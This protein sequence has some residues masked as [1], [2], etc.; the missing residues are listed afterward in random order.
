MKT[1]ATVIMNNSATSTKCSLDQSM[2]TI[3]LIPWGDTWEDWFDSVGVSFDDFCNELTGGW[4]NNY[5]DALRLAG[6]Q[7]I[8]IYA[9]AR[10]TEPS[11]FIH[12]P[13][14]ATICLLPTSKTYAAIRRQMIHPYPSL[15]YSESFEEMFGE[16]KGAKRLLLWVLKYLAPYLAMPL[17]LLI[18]EL[19]QYD[20]KA[21]LC[22]DYEQ[23]RFDVCVVLG[24]LLGLPVYSTFQGGTGDWNRIGRFLRPLTMKSCSGFVIGTQT[25]IQRVY[26]RYN[27]KS[28]QVAQIFNPVNLNRETAENRR[29]A[30]AAFGL[31]ES[32]QVVVWHGRIDIAQKG[33]ITL[34]KAWEQLCH[35]RTRQD[36]RLLLMGTGLDAET[37]QQHLSA[38]PMQNV[39]WLNKYVNDRAL[40]RQFLSTGDV[41][42]FPSRYEGF[43]VAPIEAMSCGLPLVATEVDGIPDILRNGEQSGGIVVPIDDSEAFAK[44]LGQLLDDSMLRLELGQRARKRVE[45]RFSLEVV[46]H[47]L[48]EFLLPLSPLNREHV[49]CL[50]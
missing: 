30:R 49:S 12:K 41:Y 21:I 31:P 23:A 44:A 9:S 6:V 27:L 16:V 11:R 22:Q 42:A 29:E 5:I 32:A 48:R 34:L 18:K 43:P 28:N 24:K 7:V 10:V 19:R 13:T 26:D 33:L 4:K 17:E 1:S 2:P 40:I 15:G 36:L 50:K 8:M 37:F 46:G 35:E 45:E 39:C 38:L 14:G 47:Q 25:E 3:A 20:C